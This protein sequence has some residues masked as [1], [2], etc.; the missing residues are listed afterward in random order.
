MKIHLHLFSDTGSA[1]TSDTYEFDHDPDAMACYLEGRAALE[2]SYAAVD[3]DEP[4]PLTPPAPEPEHPPRVAFGKQV[5][6]REHG[7]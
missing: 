5:A 7:E 2:A 4:A 1:I 6:A 3:D